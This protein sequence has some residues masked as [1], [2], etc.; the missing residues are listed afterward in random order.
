[1]PQS[2]HHLRRTI[3]K[4]N[5][6][7]CP[8]LPSVPPTSFLSQLMAPPLFQLLK[9]KTLGS[10]LTILLLWDF[11]QSIRKSFKIYPTAPPHFAHGKYLQWPDHPS[12]P[13][14]TY[15]LPLSTTPFH[16][17]VLASLLLLEPTSGPSR[18]TLL[19][20]HFDSSLL[21]P[22]QVF[23]QQSS[24]QWSFPEHT[25]LHSPF[26]VPTWFYPQHPSPSNLLCHLINFLFI[27]SLPPA[28]C[29]LPQSKDFSALFTIV[30]LG[31]RTVPTT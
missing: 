20:T 17:D 30:S 6:W 16:P 27:T 23:A 2:I 12:S 5:S 29:K 15:F 3:P 14:A 21:H 26:T 31:S 9:P 25:K 19:P 18:G 22:L 8:S 28:K 10:L 13:L 1:M 24:A 7:F 11:I 4:V